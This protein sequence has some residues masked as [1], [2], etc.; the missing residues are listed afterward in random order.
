[1]LAAAMTRRGPM[2]GENAKVVLRACRHIAVGYTCRMT[3]KLWGR[4]LL[5]WGIAAAA[6]SATPAI[7]LAQL[8]PAYS[9]GF[10]GLLAA[11]LT[12][13]VTPLALITASAGAILLLLAALRRDRS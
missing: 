4:G 13:S 2:I 5:V 12:L 6:I 3:T 11:L 8:P 10:F 1:M 9:D 7:L